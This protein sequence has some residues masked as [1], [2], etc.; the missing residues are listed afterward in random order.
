M[1]LKAY[2]DISQ[3]ASN[4]SAQQKIATGVQNNGFGDMGGMLFWY[5]Y[6]AECHSNRRDKIQ[7]ANNVF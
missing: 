6:G 7:S 4:I 1:D 3:K 2:E 5:E